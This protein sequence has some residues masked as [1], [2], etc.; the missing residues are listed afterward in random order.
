MTSTLHTLD[1]F[2]DFEGLL[3]V[4]E[5]ISRANFDD[6]LKTPV[7]L[8]K[9]EHITKLIVAHIHKKTRHS[10]RGITLNELRSHG[11]SMEMQWFES[12]FQSALLADT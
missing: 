1:P 8:P 12:L 2:V 7:I 4:G 11:S 10:G 9:T 6:K 3:R 5:R